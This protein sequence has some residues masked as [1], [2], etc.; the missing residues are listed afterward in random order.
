MTQIEEIARIAALP[1]IDEIERWG[2][3]RTGAKAP[4]FLERLT[5]RLKPSPDTYRG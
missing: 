4:K 3:G 1:K 2:H 5:A